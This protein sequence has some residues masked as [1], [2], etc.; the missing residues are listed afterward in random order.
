MGGILGVLVLQLARWRG[1]VTVDTVDFAAGR[2][3][4]ETQGVGVAELH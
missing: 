2:G 3:T 1:A 4:T